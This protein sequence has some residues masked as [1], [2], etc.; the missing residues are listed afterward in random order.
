[1]R[2]QVSFKADFDD[3]LAT[4][5]NLW[6]IVSRTAVPQTV[7]TSL[8]FS[9]DIRSYYKAVNND[10]KRDQDFADEARALEVTSNCR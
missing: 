8:V 1:M 7:T 3:M 4:L 5:K 2:Y 6:V 10:P 9:Y